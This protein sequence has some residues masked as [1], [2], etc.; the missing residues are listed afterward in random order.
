MEKVKTK[1][2]AMLLDYNET[3]GNKEMNLVLFNDALFHI[4]KTHRIIKFPRGHALLVGYG[5]SGKQ[6]LTKLAT[7]TAGYQIFSITLTRGY[8]EREFRDDL[9]KLYGLLCNGPCTFLF[10]DAHVIEEGFLELLN[11][12]LAIG[13]VPALFDDDGKKQMG[14]LV[15]DEAKKKGVNESKEDLWNYFLEKV[16]DNLHI[17]LCMSPAGDTLRIRCRNFP[18]LVSNTGINWFF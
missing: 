13:M 5:G 11:N 14:D 18:G 7:F 3:D 1:L 17:V 15:R 4:T 9:I 8:R 6:S 2:E 16:R 10:T 12:M